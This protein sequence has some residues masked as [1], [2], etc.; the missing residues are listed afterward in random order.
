MTDPITDFLD[1]LITYLGSVG[2]WFM[3]LVPIIIFVV[4]LLLAIYVYRDAKAKRIPGAL[5]ASLVVF[6]LT[7]I[8]GALQHWLTTNNMKKYAS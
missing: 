2:I 4:N 6:F 8:W 5:G 3:I 1:M 7:G